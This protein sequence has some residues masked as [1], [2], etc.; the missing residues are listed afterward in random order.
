VTPY[1]LLGR[2]PDRTRPFVTAYAGPHSRVELSVASV[3]NGVAKAA[4][5]LR[6]GLGLEPGAVVS[7]D[8]PRHW[9]LSVWTLAALTVGARCGRMVP[10]VVDA[11]LVGPEAL[12]AL[13]AGADPRA[14]ELLAASC[15]A[16]GLPVPGGVPRG[17]LDVGV[18]ARVHPDVYVPD[19]A[20]AASA[21]LMGP[22]GIRPWAQIRAAW[23]GAGDAAARA[24]RRRWVDESTP[25]DHVLEA[26]AITPLLTHGSVVLAT[27]LTPEQ[28][29][30]VRQAEAVMP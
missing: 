10:E 27:G 3:A 7:L 4:G 21:A 30:R 25:D 11:R 1:E 18:E 16:F 26:L 20:A 13:R 12:D 5:L 29:D 6:D 22:S 14:D 9:Q 28:A 24:G 23:A 8:L 15:D 19:P 17:V 2:F